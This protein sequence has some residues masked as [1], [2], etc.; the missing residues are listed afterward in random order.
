T[1]LLSE[2]AGRA[3][4]PRFF[5]EYSL[6]VTTFFHVEEVE[7]Q[8]KD[9]RLPVIAMLPEASLNTLMRLMQL[10]PGTCVGVVCEDSE[11]TDNLEEKNEHEHGF[12]RSRRGRNS[13]RH[14]PT[15]RL[16]QGPGR[17][18]RRSRSPGSPGEHAL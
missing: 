5:S 9:T 18:A 10:P 7:A 15:G 2:L 13:G 11:G 12:G 4:E 3:R 1:C 6:A 8:L 14:D 17:G 16:C